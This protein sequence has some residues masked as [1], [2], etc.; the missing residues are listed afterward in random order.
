MFQYEN[1]KNFLSAQIDILFILKIRDEKL[2]IDKK[3]KEF[4]IYN[5]LLYLNDID[6]TSIDAAEK[7]RDLM[8]WDT[9]D[10]VYTYRNQLKKKGWLIEDYTT[11]G[12]YNILPIFKKLKDVNQKTYQFTISCNESISD[13][14]ILK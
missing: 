2:R 5:I 3:L 8:K 6:I 7:L 14:I 1:F 11:K 10:T 12:G 13:S 9:S 4:Y